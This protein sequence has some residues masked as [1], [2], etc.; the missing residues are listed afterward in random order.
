MSA[1]PP[2]AD[3]QRPEGISPRRTSQEDAYA[4]TT[5]AIFHERVRELFYT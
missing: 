3:I 5:Q 2:K 4:D 1:L